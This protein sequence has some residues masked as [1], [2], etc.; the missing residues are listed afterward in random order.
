MDPDDFKRN[1]LLTQQ[2]C[3]DQIRATEKNEAEVLRSINPLIDGAPLFAFEKQLDGVVY[4]KWNIAPLLSTRQ[5][6]IEKVFDKQAEVK[7][8]IEVA[9]D[10]IFEGRIVCCDVGHTVTDGASE[11]VSNGFIDVYDMPPID[12]WFYVADSPAGSTLYSWIPRPFV[13]LVNDA[14]AAN[15]LDILH[16]A[17]TEEANK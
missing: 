17:E 8:S 11:T 10:V 7:A 4:A 14:I 9:S 13:S 3:Q 16:W 2:Y 1:L 6:L 15:P 12:T 5:H